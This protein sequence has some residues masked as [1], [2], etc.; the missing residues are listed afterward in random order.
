MCG[1]LVTLKRMVHTEGPQLVFTADD[2]SLMNP[3]SGN[4]ASEVID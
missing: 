3:L 1:G 2:V 4:G